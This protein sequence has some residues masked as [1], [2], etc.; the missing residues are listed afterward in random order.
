MY[1]IT[2][3]GAVDREFV[4]IGIEEF[5]R[6]TAGQAPELAGL[7]SRSGLF[8]P[9]WAEPELGWASAWAEPELGRAG[10]IARRFFDFCR[11]APNGTPTFE[12]ISG[13]HSFENCLKSRCYRRS[14]PRKVKKHCTGAP[15]IHQVP[16]FNLH[17]LRAIWNSEPDPADPPDLHNQVSETAARTLPSTRTGGQDDGS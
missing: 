14:C 5:F 15:Q 9:L 2:A 8:L 1:N 3:A 10:A 7:G 13:R 4:Y 6:R 16:I 11:T 12:S 17:R